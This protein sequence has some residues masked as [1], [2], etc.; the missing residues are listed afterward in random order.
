MGKKVMLAMS[1]G[2]DSSCS[3]LLLKKAGYEVIGATMQLYDNKDIGV[4]SKT[5]CSLSDVEDAKAVASRYNVPHYVFNFKERFNQ[6][7]IGRFNS[8]YLKGC[9][10]NPCIDCNRFLKFDALLERAVMME[11][12]YIATGH[13]ARIEY[14]ESTGR[15]LLKKA[16]SREGGNK[17]DQSYVLY[18]LTQKQLS[19]TLFPLGTMEKSDVRKLAEENGLVNYDKPDSQDICFVPN[20]NYAEFIQ[21][22]T[23]IKPTAGDVVDK[24][25]NVLGRH[26]GMINY[27]I[28]QRKGLGIAFGKPMYVIGKNAENNTVTVGES[29]DLYSDSLI[30]GELNWIS[31]ENPS[32]SFECKAKTRYSQTEQ[33]C[34]VYP[35]K[36]GTVKVVFEQPQRAITKGQRAVFYDGDTIIGGGVIL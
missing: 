19:R 33:P 34:T 2:V 25:G 15:Y 35:Q 4:E 31:V 5:C 21:Q 7:V 24:N 29:S 11:C 13:Y 27:T 30:A 18:N 32:E 3:L 12:D 28:G 22:Y 14:D 26:S 20:G 36:D 8:E 23:G 9:T 10:P 17:K 16:V 6:D 1:G